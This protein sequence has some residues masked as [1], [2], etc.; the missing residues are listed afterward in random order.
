M[1]TGQLLDRVIERLKRDKTYFRSILDMLEKRGLITI[2]SGFVRLTEKARRR[3]R[4]VMNTAVRF[5]V[6]RD[7]YSLF[8]NMMTIFYVVAAST[9]PLTEEEAIASAYILATIAMGGQDG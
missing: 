3:A 2:S 8:T 7:D 5:D 9:G 4:E 1:D 6:V